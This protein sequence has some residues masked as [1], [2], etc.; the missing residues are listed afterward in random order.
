V[1]FAADDGGWSGRRSAHIR[2]TL[3]VQHSWEAADSKSMPRPAHPAEAVP[4]SPPSKAYHGLPR[5][6]HAH[7]ATQPP[8]STS[9]RGGEQSAVCI[10]RWLDPPVAP[11]R[12]PCYL[13]HVHRARAPV[14]RCC[15]SRPPRLRLRNRLR[16]MTVGE[17]AS[18]NVPARFGSISTREVRGGPWLLPRLGVIPPRTTR[19][20]LAAQHACSERAH[21]S[22]GMEAHRRSRWRPDRAPTPCAVPH[23][24]FFPHSPPAAGGSPETPSP[25]RAPPCTPPTSATPRRAR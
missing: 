21:K 15:R 22:A 23:P 2:C 6:L 17:A 9:A 1:A 11:T 16:R 19:V 7:P 25:P 4:T 5:R 12:F 8:Q 20:P 18:T 13:G 3:D 14:L 10:R 24:L